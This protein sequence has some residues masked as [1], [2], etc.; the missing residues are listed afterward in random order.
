[1][2]LNYCQAFWLKSCPVL[3]ENRG[4]EV[5]DVANGFGSQDSATRASAMKVEEDR[6][7]KF[8]EGG[9]PIDRNVR[10]VPSLFWSM[11]E[12]DHG[13]ERRYTP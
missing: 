6:V 7:F 12:F 5:S 2:T 8:K 4:R 13:I 9:D 10:F 11:D 1:M 3:V